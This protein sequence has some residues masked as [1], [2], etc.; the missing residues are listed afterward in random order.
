M[1]R[2]TPGKWLND[3]R[4]DYASQLLL[5]SDLNINE[6]GYE[7]GFSNSSHFNKSFKDKYQVT[8]KQFR[9]AKR[10]TL[11]MAES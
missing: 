3:K 4:L 5:S 9:I 2:Q 1:Y 10:G 11:N 8:P 6:I 7:C